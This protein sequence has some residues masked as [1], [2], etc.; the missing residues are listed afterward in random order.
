MPCEHNWHTVA[1]KRGDLFGR[2]ICGEYE[3]LPV[4]FD[5][6]RIGLPVKCLTCGAKGV[7][8]WYNPEVEEV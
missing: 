2:P 7:Q 6:D 1:N 8:W 5:N 3:M 4:K